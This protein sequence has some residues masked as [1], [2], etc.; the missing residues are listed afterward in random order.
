MKERILEALTT[1]AVISMM[2]EFG[3]TYT[4]TRSDIRFLPVCHNG[5]HHTLIYYENT[6]M[7]NCLTCC[8]WMDIFTL[9]QKVKGCDF[10]TAINF[11]SNRLG[12]N[13]NVGFINTRRSN[14]EK[15][16]ALYD[17]STT[18]PA[19]IPC[20]DVSLINYFED[21]YY[22]GWVEEGI[23]CE[24]MKRF[25][26]KWYEYKKWIIIPC[27]DINGNIIGIRRRALPYRDDEGNIIQPEDKYRPLQMCGYDFTFSTG[28]TLYGLY[29]NKEAICKQHICVVFEGEK[30]VMK[31]VTMFGEYPCVAVYG[32]NVS[33]EQINQLKQLDVHKVI[34]AF[35]YDDAND[36]QKARKTAK[37]IRDKGLQCEYIS[38][39]TDWLW[40]NKHDAP[41]DQGKEIYLKLLKDRKK[42]N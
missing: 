5:D 20:E 42:E 4:K 17:T 30:S 36:E 3:S 18:P 12:I 7:F 34:L 24:V 39:E 27:K 28:R 26:I 31:A 35:D 8:G 21:K 14:L 38:Y 29:E 15:I 2:Q 23:S 11:L 16:K 32:S 6:K 37:K 22:E 25:G 40:M 10:R 41:V 33:Y 1:E 13:P 9:V 19:I